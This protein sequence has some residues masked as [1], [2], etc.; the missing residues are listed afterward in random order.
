MSNSVLDDLKY[1]SAAD[2]GG[3]LTAVEGFCDQWEEATG[4]GMDFE[5]PKLSGIESV[6]ILGM[7]G[8]AIAGDFLRAYLQDDCPIPI[9]VVRGY[10]LP[11]W[12]GKSTLV[13]ASSY[14]GNT[15]ETLTST[16][17]ALRRGC[18]VIGITTGGKLEKIHE[19]SGVAPV[20]LIK[21][22]PG[23]S[24][25]AVIG[26][27]FVPLLVMLGKLGFASDQKAVLEE[28]H[29]VLKGTCA[30]YGR[31]KKTGNNPAKD[32]A[33]RLFGRF[34]IVY[35]GGGV[36]EAVSYRWRCQFNENSK[37]LA[38]S[39]VVPE[40]NHNEI[41]G[42]EGPRHL[43]T[44]SVVIYL[45][46]ESNRR[47]VNA[48]FEFMQPLIEKGGGRVVEFRGEGKS[49]LSRIFSMVNLGDFVSVYL[50]LLEGVDPTPVYAIDTIKAHLE[51]FAG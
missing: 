45:C 7:G 46:D 22:P 51:T 10:D 21:I 19:E 9:V 28:A 6:A 33:H 40:M 48:R 15:E 11:K 8:S 12:V 37:R 13:I 47:E 1:C 17:E 23:F 43:T 44:S 41:V 36:F 29:Q 20:P 38:G 39:H 2:P 49:V 35:C 5:P 3:M 18:P 26:Y 16:G 32:L 4:I 50:A 30:A 42:W 14:S 25:R 34:P 24:P 31:S 27:S